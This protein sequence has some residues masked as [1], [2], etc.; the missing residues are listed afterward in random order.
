MSN[1]KPMLAHA[2]YTPLRKDQ[3][4]VRSA[5]MSYRLEPEA[6]GSLSLGLDFRWLWALP[7][8]SEAWGRKELTLHL[9][10]TVLG[11]G[12]PASQKVDVSQYSQPHGDNWRARTSS[13]ESN[14]NTMVTCQIS[15]KI[16]CFKSE[17]VMQLSVLKSLPFINIPF[18]MENGGGGGT[19]VKEDSIK[20]HHE[21]NHIL[22]T[23]DTVQRQLTY[24]P[25]RRLT[26]S[27]AASKG[28][29]AWSGLVRQFPESP[30]KRKPFNDGKIIW[31]LKHS[32]R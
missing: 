15:D 21:T 29:A 23:Q 18:T 7:G 19:P 30:R 24:S 20:R 11:N 9:D 17:W 2:P 32:Y 22:Q 10:S 8:L 6:E 3:T 26:H 27:A 1:A 25:I 16:M 14:V 12:S 5:P 28:T 31:E 13:A 4:W